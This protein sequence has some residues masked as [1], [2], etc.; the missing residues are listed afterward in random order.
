MAPLSH[1]AT[2]ANLRTRHVLRLSL[3]QFNSGN[4]LFHLHLHFFRLSVSTEGKSPPVFTLFSEVLPLSAECHQTTSAA[5]FLSIFPHSLHPGYLLRNDSTSD[6]PTCTYFAQCTHFEVLVRLVHQVQ[7]LNS[8]SLLI[9]YTSEFNKMSGKMD[10]PHPCNRH[11][12]IIT[13]KF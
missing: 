10:I 2:E 7:R 9:K 12:R 11:K 6:L 13:I 8:Q 4:E 1:R 5:L 3:V